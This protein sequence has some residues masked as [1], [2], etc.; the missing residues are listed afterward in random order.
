MLVA[1]DDPDVRDLVVFKLEQAGFTVVAVGDGSEALALALA[2]PP[3]LALVDVMMPGLSGLDV[4]RELR[5]HPA[6]AQVP[7]IMLTARSQESDVDA[8]FRTGVDD[9]VTK[10]FSPRELVNRVQAVLARAST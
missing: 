3:D 6:T 2:E 4:T 8:G 5:R 1:E 10:P 7:V 9:Y